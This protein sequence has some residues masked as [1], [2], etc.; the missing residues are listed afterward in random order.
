MCYFSGAT[1]EGVWREAISQIRWTVDGATGPT[2]GPVLEPVAAAWNQASD[3]A[4]ILRKLTKVIL[5]EWTVI[6]ALKALK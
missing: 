3:S 1:E 4:T 6:W 2:G 5:L